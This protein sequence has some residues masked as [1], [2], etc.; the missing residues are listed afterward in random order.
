VTCL[1]RHRGEGGATRQSKEAGDQH[2]APTALP[3]EKNNILITGGWVGLGAGLKGTERIAPHRDSIP[4]PSSPLL[5]A[6]QHS[7]SRAVPHL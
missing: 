3:P 5:P 7:D 6:V 1:C 4:G 2:H